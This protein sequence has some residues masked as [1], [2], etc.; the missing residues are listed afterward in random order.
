MRK[1]AWVVMFAL[2]VLSA[3]GCFFRAGG[4]LSVPPPPTATV[5]VGAS[6]AP[7]PP[8]VVGAQTNVI[9]ATVA[10]PTPTYAAN[11]Q[12]LG[13]S[14]SPGAAE[15]L[16]GLD[17]NCNGQIDEGWVQ[18]GTLQITLGWSTGADLDLWHFG[19][20]PLHIAGHAFSATRSRSRPTNIS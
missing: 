6:V 17:D 19:C 11:V 4:T 2:V 15:V 10:A 8:V 1:A 7:P 13:T 14:C 20:D 16:N 18:S 5:T 12:V 9:H 3:S